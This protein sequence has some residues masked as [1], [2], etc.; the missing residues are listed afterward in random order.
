[1]QL[2]SL[3]TM[4]LK[5]RDLGLISGSIL[6]GMREQPD[7]LALIG[8]WVRISRVLM[9][10]ELTF[11]DFRSGIKQDMYLKENLTRA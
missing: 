7:R 8:N 10:L 2:I 9:V 4:T 11:Q 3:I 1:M 5:S 6:S